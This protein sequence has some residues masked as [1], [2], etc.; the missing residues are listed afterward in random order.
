MSKVKDLPASELFSLDPGRDEIEPDHYY[1]GGRIPVFKPVGPLGH[2]SY[3]ISLLPL[4]CVKL[5]AE[6]GHRLEC[7]CVVWWCAYHILPL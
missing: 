7:A 1:G 4:I 3:L 2:I 6:G 5:R